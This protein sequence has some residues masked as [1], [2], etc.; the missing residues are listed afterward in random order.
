MQSSAQERETSEDRV[1]VDE[2]QSK[3]MEGINE[4][5]GTVE[6]YAKEHPRIAVGVAVGIG[7][8]L[9]GGITPRILFGLGALMARRYAKDY[10]RNQLGAVTKGI[11]FGGEEEVEPKPRHVAAKRT[12]AKEKE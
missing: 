4:L 3:A 7:F 5:R 8:V 12:S 10:A 1:D 2:M 11:F 9:G 6:A